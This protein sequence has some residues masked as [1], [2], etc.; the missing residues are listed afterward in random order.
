MVIGISTDP[1][2]AQQKFTEKENLNFPLFSD[3]EKKAAAA[4]GALSPRGF[5]K[6]MTVV[7]DK[8]GVVRKIYPEV[9]NAGEHPKEVLE[10]VQK[11]LAK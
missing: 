8:E 6:R 11:D 2:S 4:Y 3:Q 5:A 7:I 1:L 10:Y 9:K